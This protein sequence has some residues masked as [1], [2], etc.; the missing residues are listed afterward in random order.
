MREEATTRTGDSISHRPRPL[1][2]ERATTR[3]GRNPRFRGRGRLA[4]GSLFFP[5]SSPNVQSWV[6]RATLKPLLSV[7]CLSEAKNA[8]LH[9]GGAASRQRSREGRERA[10]GRPSLWIPS[11]R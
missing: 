1:M 3:T 8:A 5:P 11:L 2:R 10:E 7:S 9:E 6:F 4:N